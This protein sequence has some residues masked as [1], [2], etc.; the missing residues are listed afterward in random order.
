VKSGKLTFETDGQIDVDL[1]V[2][3]NDYKEEPEKEV[4]LEKKVE[5]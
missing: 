2:H 4:K 1:V 3:E 5:L